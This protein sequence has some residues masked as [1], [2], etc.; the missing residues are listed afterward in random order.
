MIKPK[1]PQ[2]VRFK[3]SEIKEIRETLGKT[4]KEFARYFPV[5]EAT[6]KAWENGW[7][8]P[9][10]PSSTILQQLKSYAD[11]V[12]QEKQQALKGLLN[13]NNQG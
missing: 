5:S 13:K 9:Y 10:G 6:I 12:K 7:R 1:Y 2:T 8:N 11:H 3:P 4:Q